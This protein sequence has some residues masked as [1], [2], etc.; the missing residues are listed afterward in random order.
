MR[1]GETCKRGRGEGTV[2]LKHTQHVQSSDH[3]TIGATI[4][5]ITIARTI[6]N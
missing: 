4:D 2:L 6:A 3:K 1:E 5:W